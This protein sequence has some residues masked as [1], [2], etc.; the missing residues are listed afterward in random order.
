MMVLRQPLH[1][2]KLLQLSAWHH[3]H[4]PACCQAACNGHNSNL[5]LLY[6]FPQQM[7]GFITGHNPVISC[8]LCVL[9]CQQLCQRVLAQI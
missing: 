9:P 1:A 4:A 7:Q 5:C 6:G 3:Q 8:G 2:L